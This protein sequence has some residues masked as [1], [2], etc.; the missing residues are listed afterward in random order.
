MALNTVKYQFNEHITKGTQYEK[1][2][3]TNNRKFCEAG[4]NISDAK[5]MREFAKRVK[6]RTKGY[7]FLETP[8]V[9]HISCTAY[10]TSH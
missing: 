2:D 7:V 6:E 9:H 10:Q 4:R 3:C 8:L 1:C 5:A